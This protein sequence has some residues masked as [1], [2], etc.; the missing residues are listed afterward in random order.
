MFQTAPSSQLSQTLKIHFYLKHF[1]SSTVD[2]ILKET[3][4]ESIT[5]YE[6]LCRETDLFPAT[7]SVNGYLFAERP[8][9]DETT[10]RV[11]E[12]SLHHLD[13]YVR[14]R[15]MKYYIGMDLTDYELLY[16]DQNTLYVYVPYRE[17]DDEEEEDDF[18]EEASVEEEA[19]EDEVVSSEEE[20]SEEEDVDDDQSDV[21]DE[22]DETEDDQEDK[23]LQGWVFSLNTA[24]NN[25]YILRPQWK[26][27][28]VQNGVVT[29]GNES[30]KTTW[31]LPIDGLNRPIYFNQ[32]YG[33]WIVS[34]TLQKPLIDA[35]A[36]EL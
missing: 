15:I 9:V 24:T 27:Y 12:L 19:S 16:P 10:Y 25:S 3:G 29:W 2:Y 11:F 7:I 36:T 28:K 21:S 13:Y 22:D 33:G 8:E 35:G 20:V 30:Q 6:M 18:D 23:P 31:N 17:T 5:Q 32:K 34:L 14:E 26:T 4:Y 1:R